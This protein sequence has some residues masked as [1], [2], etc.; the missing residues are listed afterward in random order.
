MVANLKI[1][2]AVC[3]A[4][5]AVDL[6]LTMYLIIRQNFTF[7]MFGAGGAIV[8]IAL[9]GMLLRYLR[10]ERIIGAESCPDEE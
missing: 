3:S 7:A 10:V 4:V 6:S 5:F 9:L 8:M 1:L 2:I